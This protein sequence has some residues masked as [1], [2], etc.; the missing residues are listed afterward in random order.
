MGDPVEFARQGRS[1]GTLAI[2]IVIYAVLLAAII[3]VDAAWWLMSALALLTLPAV[4]DLW[5]DPGAGLRLGEN[6]LDWH[7][8]Q[9]SAIL[10][11][12]EIDHMRFDTR[13]DFSVR[14]TAELKNGKRIR[15]PYEALPP[16]LAL[17]AGFKARGIAVVRH[18][19]TVF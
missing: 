13:W 10:E 4:W 5:R 9:R 15:L 6:R 11:L 16:H 7:S 1:P 8:G 12:N 3:L 18:H 2:L 17:E 14:V 19:F